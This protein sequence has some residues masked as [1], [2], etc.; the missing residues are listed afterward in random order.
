MLIDNRNHLSEV[1]RWADLFIQT[2][3]IPVAFL[4]IGYEIH[5]LHHSLFDCDESLFQSF[6]NF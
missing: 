5:K 2:P 3:P 4:H 6:H 1:K